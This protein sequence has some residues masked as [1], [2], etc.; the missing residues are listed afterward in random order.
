MN[1]TQ[2]NSASDLFDENRIVLRQKRAF[3]RN[4]DSADFL[5]QRIGE[6]FAFRIGSVNRQFQ[7]VA[8]MFSLFDVVSRSLNDLDNVTGIIAL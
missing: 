6:D 3:A 8:D 5:A 4:S 2:E 7:N 1:S